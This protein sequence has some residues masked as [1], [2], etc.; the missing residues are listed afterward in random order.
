MRIQDC[1][2]I[3]VWDLGFS[4]ITEQE[5]GTWKET[6][7]VEKLRVDCSVGGSLTL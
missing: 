1:L 3:R 5:H 2:G 4:R 6:E 7:I